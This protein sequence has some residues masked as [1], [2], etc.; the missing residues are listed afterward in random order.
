MK[1]SKHIWMVALIVSSL[2]L[3]SCYPLI[4]KQGDMENVRRQFHLSRAISFKSFESYPKTPGF[5]GRE[6][7]SITATLEFSK[8]QF[9]EYVRHL[10]DDDVWKPV[11][12]LYYSPSIG[13]EYSTKALYWN[14]LPLPDSLSG[15]MDEIGLEVKGLDVHQGKYYCSVILTVRG[16]P[17]ES[18]PAAYHWNQVGMSCTELSESEFPTLLAFA[19]LDY[20][21]R[22]LHIYIQF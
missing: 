3:S 13:D 7:L 8:E 12:Y 19:V 9:E 11:S 6:G 2:L 1:F 5:F 18:N 21:K 17:L 15:W 16:E 20:E 10:N 4:F 22:L 14:D